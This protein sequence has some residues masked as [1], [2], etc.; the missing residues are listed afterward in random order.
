MPQGGGDMAN[1]HHDDENFPE[2]AMDEMRDVVQP[3]HLAGHR[4]YRKA[5]EA[6][7]LV[8]R[9]QPQIAEDRHDQRDAVEGGMT[10]AGG[11][12]Q[13]RAVAER[14]R[15]AVIQP[16]AEAEEGQAEDQDRKSTRLNSSH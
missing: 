14:R 13:Q 4:L 9:R 8:T 11:E 1:D 2:L 3:R 7:D 16:P 10:G 5:E 6:G 15:R 12:A